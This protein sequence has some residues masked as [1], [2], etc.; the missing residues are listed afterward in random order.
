M[1]TRSQSRPSKTVKRGRQA[2]TRITIGRLT[3]EEALLA[4]LIAAMNANGHVTPEEA[5]RAHH[6][7]WS[8][9]RFRRK[10][11]D[12]VGRGIERMRMLV[13]QHGALPVLDAGARSIP[14]RLRPAAFAL[15]AD[16]VLADGKIEP[17][18]R[19]FLDRLAAD[20]R[21]DRK[22]AGQIRD[23]MLVKNSA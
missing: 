22:T 7:I 8:M 15:A 21:L 4:F 10:S 23:V 5:A 20:L 1:R 18:E 3:L 17:S 12:T 9:R 6:L 19:R 11:G 16:L 2:A 13:E 14:S